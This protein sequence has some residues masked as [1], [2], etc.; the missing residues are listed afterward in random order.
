MKDLL[1]RLALSSEPQIGKF[2][3]VVRQTTSKNCTKGRA[4]RAARLFFLFQTIILL[5]C[6]IVVTFAVVVP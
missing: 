2:H 3:V 5:I 6:D 4:A 1:L